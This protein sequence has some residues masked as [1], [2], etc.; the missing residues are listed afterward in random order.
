VT[1]GQVAK[2]LG[3]TRS[4]VHQ[5]DA[6]LRPERCAC[7]GR[8]YSEAAVAAYE[9]RIP[10]LRAAVA[11]ERAERMRRLRRRVGGQ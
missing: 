6:E 9:A 11:A 3:V 10:E 8:V 1:A 5:L 4:R 2:R 7:G